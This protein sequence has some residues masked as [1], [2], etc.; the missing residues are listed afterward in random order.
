MSNSV[1]IYKGSDHTIRFSLYDN[2]NAQV[3]GAT[4]TWNVG[5]TSSLTSTE[6]AGVYT[7]VI[8]DNIALEVGQYTTYLTSIVATEQEIYKVDLIVT[9]RTL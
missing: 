7:F 9:Y 3:T 2:N 6:S 1:T 5:L 4:L 8:A